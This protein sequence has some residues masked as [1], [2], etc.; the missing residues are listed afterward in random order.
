M[1][2]VILETTRNGMPANLLTV[3][4]F[5]LKNEDRENKGGAIWLDGF[6]EASSGTDSST[7]LSKST[8]FPRRMSTRNVAVKGILNGSNPLTYLKVYL[9]KNISQSTPQVD[10]INTITVTL[11]LNI[12]LHSAQASEVKL[13]PLFSICYSAFLSLHPPERD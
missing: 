12:Q 6:V 10:A 4:T 9:V 7:A 13:D 3:V 8:M 5:V 1:G 2:S 11:Q